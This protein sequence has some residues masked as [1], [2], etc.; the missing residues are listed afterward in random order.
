M[1]KNIKESM[2]LHSMSKNIKESM[3]LHSRHSLA[4]REEDSEQILSTKT[5]RKRKRLEVEFDTT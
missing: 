5:G 2:F 1:S 3:F 4:A